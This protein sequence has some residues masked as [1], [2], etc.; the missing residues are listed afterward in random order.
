MM[1]KM[2]PPRSI[3]LKLLD[4]MTQKAFGYLMQVSFNYVINLI[5]FVFLRGQLQ[6]VLLCSFVN[7][8]IGSLKFYSLLQLTVASL[9]WSQAE[10]RII[11]LQA[12]QIQKMTTFITPNVNLLSW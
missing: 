5:S 1:A 9:K 4:V 12:E 10:K 2:V 3:R 7:F 11:L 8:P 6:K